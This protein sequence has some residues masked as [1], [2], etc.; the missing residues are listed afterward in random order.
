MASRLKFDL[1]GHR[2]Q[3]WPKI[4]ITLNNSVIYNDRIIDSCNLEFLVDFDDTNQL[5]IELHDKNND[6]VVDANGQVVADCHAV[7]NCI[8]IDHI[9]LDINDFSSYQFLYN[10]N[11]GERFVTNYL[12]KEGHLTV[13]FRWPAWKF[14]YDLRSRPQ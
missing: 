7:I 10:S 12:G 9:R 2:A 4:K 1:H 3:H 8:Y 11:D 6:T 5:S 14:W 13:N